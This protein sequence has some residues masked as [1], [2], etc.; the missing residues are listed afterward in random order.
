MTGDIDD[1]DVFYG[2]KKKARKE[3]EAAPEKKPTYGEPAYQP[4]YSEQAKPAPAGSAQTAPEQERDIE[5]EITAA[6]HEK[7]QAAELHDVTKL[8]QQA[9]KHS[10]DA[11]KLYKKF[12]SEEAAMVKH[13]ENSNKARR[14]AEK[15]EQKS[16][17]TTAKADDKQSDLEFLKDRKAERARIKIAKL[18]AKSAKL[19]S[20]SSAYLAK[21]AKLSQKSAAKREKAKAMLEKS[22]MHEAEAHNLT[23]RADRLSKV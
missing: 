15:Y 14:A 11:A 7:Q 1:D 9:A 23:K 6:R 12:R 22:K 3:N 17:E 18:H 2:N 4:R 10:A 5:S 16:K 19:K 13:A 8:R 20:R 21:A